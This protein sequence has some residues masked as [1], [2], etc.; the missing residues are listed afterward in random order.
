MNLKDYHTTQELKTLYRTEK[1]ARLARR[2][3]SVY[4]VAKRLSC[5]QIMAIAGAA[6]RTIQPWIHKYNKHRIDRL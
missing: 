1:D 2:I 3:H 6:G 4:L 5:T